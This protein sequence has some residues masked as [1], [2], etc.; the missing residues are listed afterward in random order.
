MAEFNKNADEPIIAAKSDRFGRADF[1]KGLAEALVK[2]P[3]SQSFTVGLHGAWGSGKTSIIKMAEEYLGRR[4]K[5]D[6]I[7]INFNPWVF[8]NVDSLHVALFGA[9]AQGLGKRLSKEI[10][11][12]LR[13]YA[14]LTGA[15]GAVIAPFFPPSPILARVLSGGM[16]ALSSNKKAVSADSIKLRVDKLLKDSKKRVI[17]IIDDIDR[18]DSDEIHL[19]FKLVKNVAHFSNISYLLAFD[20]KVVAKALAGRYPDEPEIGGNFV[21]KIV[22]LSLFVPPVDREVLGQFMLE[23]I[24]AI[25]DKREV[26]VSEKEISRFQSAYSNLLSE[27]FSTPRKVVR[28]LN[29]VDFAF[30]RLANEANFTDVMLVEALGIFEPELYARISTK[31][32][33][34]IDWGHYRHTDDK[35]KEAAKIEVFGTD[36]PIAWPA[37][38]I[39]ELFPSYEWAIGGS[40]YSGEFIKH[41]DEDQRVC[42]A[43]Y[44]DRYFNYGVPIG[45]VPDAKLRDFLELLTH[46]DTTQDEANTALRKLVES[47]QPNVLVSKLRNKEDDLPKGVCEKL[48]PAL[49]SIGSD[50]PRAQQSF[51]GDTFSSYVQ[52]AILAVHLTR[53]VNNTFTMLKAFMDDASLDYAEQLIRWIRVNTENDKNDESFVPLITKQQLNI[54]G[55]IL[56]VRVKEYSDSGDLTKDF[57][58]NLPALMWAWNKWGSSKAINSYMVGA[59]AKDNH[60]AIAF[61]DSYVGHAYD[62]LSGR[63]SRSEFRRESYDEIAK[64]IDPDVF[65]KPLIELYGDG[66]NVDTDEFPLGRFNKEEPFE[67][68]IA[69][70]FLYIHRAVGKE[71]ATT[72]KKLPNIVNP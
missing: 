32:N 59:F 40:S 35:Q 42:S 22:Q 64:Y 66:I 50:F 37:G 61:L 29:A 58:D 45:D 12:D 70:Q 11:I 41:W 17:V 8:S 23:S 52:S 72:D 20:Q 2:V 39:R 16:S 24:N 47:G 1:A 25:A 15:A 34:L 26:K 14:Q 6:V 54:L 30:E 62:M 57:H 4:Y 60:S 53:N 65:V 51:M 56:A 71:I 3:D 38:I 63:K 67:Q 28:Y 13:K 31:K 27:L 68:L 46:P 49:V 9:L 18:L 5:D 69:K 7:V 43:K 36:H 21:E 19:V 33:V 10:A 55:K 48:A 44:F